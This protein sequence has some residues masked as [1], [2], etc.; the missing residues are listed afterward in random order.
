MARFLSLAECS[1]E[2][3]NP[4]TVFEDYTH[5]RVLSVTETSC[6]TVDAHWYK[7]AGEN[8]SGC[9][10]KGGGLY[11]SVWVTLNRHCRPSTSLPSLRWCSWR[12]GKY[13]S[14]FAS[15]ASET[16]LYGLSTDRT[17]WSVGQLHLASACFD[18]KG[19]TCSVQERLLWHD[20]VDF[21]HVTV[22]QW[23]SVLFCFFQLDQLD[24]YSGSA[25]CAVLVH[26]FHIPSL[27]LRFICLFV[28][29]F[30]HGCHV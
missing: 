29:F 13:F 24:C 30:L 8:S 1:W 15:P 10:K 7:N 14:R 3:P 23:R 20:P 22:H 19:S 4:F 27:F 18:I 28:C 26:A 9:L 11:Y 12:L 25:N 6:S 16:G 21:M 2:T 5:K 17:L